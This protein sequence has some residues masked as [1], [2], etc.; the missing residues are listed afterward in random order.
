MTFVTLRHFFDHLCSRAEKK[1]EEKKGEKA[2]NPGASTKNRELQ[3]V[4]LRL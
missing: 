1:G 3:G 2:N 4:R